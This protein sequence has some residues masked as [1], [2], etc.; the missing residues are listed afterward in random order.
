MTESVKNVS[1]DYQ[2]NQDG[3]VGGDLIRLDCRY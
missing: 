3:T 1:N 2:S